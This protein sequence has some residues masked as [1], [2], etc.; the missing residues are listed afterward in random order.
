MNSSMHQEPFTAA[1]IDSTLLFAR[2]DRKNPKAHSREDHSDE[3]VR[4]LLLK[5]ASA[6]RRE[7]KTST[8][9]LDAKDERVLAKPQLTQ[10]FSKIFTRISHEGKDVTFRLNP[11]FAAQLAKQIQD[12]QHR[13]A[14]RAQSQDRRA[15]RALKS[16]SVLKSSL[17]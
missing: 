8:V 7:A 2:L 5:V 15:A 6:Y 13:E 16:E 10:K 17:R 1:Q 12:E 9:T 4:D 3:E 14:H 11:I